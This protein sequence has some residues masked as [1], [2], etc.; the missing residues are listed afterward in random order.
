MTLLEEDWTMREVAQAE[1]IKL[2]GRD[3]ELRAWIS[4]SDLWIAI[5]RGS[6]APNEFPSTTYTKGGRGERKDEFQEF[7]LGIII[8][9]LHNIRKLHAMTTRDHAGRTVPSFGLEVNLITART[10]LAGRP[11]LHFVRTFHHSTS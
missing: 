8:R 4:K 11:A 10:P 6:I 1:L 2:S 3:L 5:S 7:L 9:L